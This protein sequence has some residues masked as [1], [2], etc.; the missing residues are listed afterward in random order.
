ALHVA[1]KRYL[2]AVEPGYIQSL[3]EASLQSLALQ[4]GPLSERQA[5]RFE[6]GAHF[7]DAVRLRRYDEGGK[8]DE[9]VGKTLRDYGD[10]LEEVA[11]RGR[12]AAI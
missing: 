5:R 2:C 11:A 9:V 7:A 6:R 1:A 10:L 8:R 3:S 4:G 12:R